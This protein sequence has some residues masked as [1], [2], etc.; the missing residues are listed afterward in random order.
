MGSWAQM[1][2]LLLFR[3]IQGSESYLHSDFQALKRQQG[4]TCVCVCVS[5]SMHSMLQAALLLDEK[6]QH[7][8]KQAHAALSAALSSID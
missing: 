5:Y 4:N 3:L 1:V 8:C 7:L 2:C 6:R